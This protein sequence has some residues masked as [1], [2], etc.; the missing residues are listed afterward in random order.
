MD[1]WRKE[2]KHNH[3]TK[4]SLTN[5]VLNQHNSPANRKNNNSENKDN[6]KIC[7]LMSI[8][9][10]ETSLCSILNWLWCLISRVYAFYC[11]SRFVYRV[12]MC[13]RASVCASVCMDGCECLCELRTC[14]TCTHLRNYLFFW[15]LQIARCYFSRKYN[16]DRVEMKVR[17]GGKYWGRRV[18]D[19]LFSPLILLPLYPFP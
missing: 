1:D 11:D 8:V 14:Y 3:N 7:R 13:F 17:I 5:E 6:D 19:L 12:R 4:R 15:C 10:L 9:V 2:R 18:A 16:K